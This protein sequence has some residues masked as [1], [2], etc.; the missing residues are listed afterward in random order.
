MTDRCTFSSGH[1]TAGGQT[2][3]RTTP[4]RQGE[5][6]F[7]THYCR[8]RFSEP[9]RR[10]SHVSTRFASMK[11]P[12]VASR[13]RPDPVA[14]QGELH[15]TP[16]RR[17]SRRSQP[18]GGHQK[19][20]NGGR[21]PRVGAGSQLVSGAF[22]G[23]RGRSKRRLESLPLACTR[24]ALLLLHEIFPRRAGAPREGVRLKQQELAVAAT[25]SPVGRSW[26][27]TSHTARR[28]ASPV[29]ASARRLVGQHEPGWRC[30]RSDLRSTALPE[31]SMGGVP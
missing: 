8:S 1:S 13:T 12:F 15:G 23:E 4:H 25:R 3:R 6:L 19:L 29:S 18:Q 24:E 30:S 22:H 9:A 16:T 7:A 14:G 2:R 5:R 10:P 27:A 11:Q 26:P 28:A 31:K 21:H 17:P 20:P